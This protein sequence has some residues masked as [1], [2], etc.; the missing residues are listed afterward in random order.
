MLE[1]IDWDEMAEVLPAIDLMSAVEE[2]FVAYS[3]GRAT[4]APVSELCLSHGEVH[5]KTGCILGDTTFVT[6]IA[7]G[8]YGNPASG[9]S[10]SNGLMLIFD[11]ETGVPLTLLNDEGHLTNIR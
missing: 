1:V 3:S 8:F 2:G 10:S 7:T 4:V 9:L 5:L 11:S 6:K